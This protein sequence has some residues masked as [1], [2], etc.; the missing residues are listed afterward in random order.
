MFQRVDHLCVPGR[1]RS[2]RVQDA[3]FQAFPRNGASR[4]LS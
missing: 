1:L 2:G 4:L 3:L